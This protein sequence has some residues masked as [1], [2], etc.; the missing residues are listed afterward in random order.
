[1]IQVEYLPTASLNAAPYNP[2]K[3]PD[4]Q[5]A[6][7]MHG[8]EAFGLVDPIIVNQSTGNIVGGHQ[9]V[10][11][12]KR[13]KLAEVPVVHV[14]LDRD[15][16]KAL[17]LALNKISGEWDLD[18]LR[19]ILG[20]LSADDFDMDLTGFSAGEVADLLA[21]GLAGDD[22]EH[23]PGDP[24]EVP[25]VDEQ[26]PPVTKPG[27][28]IVLGAHRLLCG[29]STKAEDVARLMD[30]ASINACITSPPYASQRKY[31]ESSGF[32]PIPP[33]DYVEW[34]GAVA[35]NIKAHMAPDGS[36]FCNIKEHCED[37]ERHLYV[38]DLTIAHV[39][40]WG[41]RFVDEFCWKRKGVP[42]G[43]EYRFKNE[44]EPVFHFSVGVP[45]CNR[46][47]VAVESDQCFTAKDNASA[48]S[49]AG[50]SVFNCNAANGKEMYTGMALPGN[51]LEVNG[52]TEAEHNAAYPVGLPEFFIKAFSDDGDAVYDP[53]MGSGTTLIACEQHGRVAYGVELSP[54]YCDVIVRRWEKFT[55]KTAQRPER[56]VASGRK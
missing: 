15:Q 44:W 12:A 47:A 56:E 17:N 43:W 45:K 48:K 2:R 34:Y 31:D 7:L 39:R 16:E 30:G 3:M 24:D 29:D 33:A 52:Q 9:R 36:Y 25:E 6:R 41:W 49:K 35:A 8:I 1:M 50:K 11:A 5:M 19:G 37:G 38:K 54:A 4:E 18:L 46:Y 53:F 27:D 28:L 14:T 21:G 55:G 13:L 20:D 51:V 23:E 26:A 42:G 40:A 22:P 10:E 32:K